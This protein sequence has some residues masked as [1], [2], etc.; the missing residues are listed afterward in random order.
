MSVHITLTDQ[1]CTQALMTKWLAQTLPFIC[2]T[3]K[4]K[5]GWK[6]QASMGYCILVG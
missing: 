1:F 5:T 2:V 3:N 6:L 4:H